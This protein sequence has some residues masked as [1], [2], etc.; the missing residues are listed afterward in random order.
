MLGDLNSLLEDC[1]KSILDHCTTVPVQYYAT[2]L[3]LFVPNRGE[4]KKWGTFHI[5]FEKQKQKNTVRRVE[6]VRLRGLHCVRLLF[7]PRLIRQRYTERRRLAPE[8]MGSN[9]HTHTQ[10]RTQLT[11]VTNIVEREF[12]ATAILSYFIKY[13]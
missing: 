2:H 3:C 6:K 7:K 11:I 8:Y 13:K 5:H 10:Q 9:T 12:V 1:R 4:T